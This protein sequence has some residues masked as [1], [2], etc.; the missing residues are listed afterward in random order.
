MAVEYGKNGR[1]RNQGGVIAS[2]NG[3]SQSDNKRCL[4]SAYRELIIKYRNN[5]KNSVYSIECTVHN[6]NCSMDY[7]F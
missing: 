5:N 7:Y 1:N 4:E 2:A 3:I 6:D